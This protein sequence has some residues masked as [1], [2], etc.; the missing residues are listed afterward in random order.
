MLCSVLIK[1]QQSRNGGELSQ[2]EKKIYKNPTTNI[3]LNGW[4]TKNFP[5]KIKKKAGM[6]TAITPFQHCTRSWSEF[7]KT[8]KKK[9]VKG[10]GKEEIKLSLFTDNMIIYIDNLKMNKNNYAT[11][12]WW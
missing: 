12:K 6:F 10:I 9:E 4:E 5:T 3:I 1:N 8:K 2:L 7:S 11:N